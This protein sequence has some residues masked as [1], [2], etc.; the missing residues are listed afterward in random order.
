[1]I[2]LEGQRTLGPWGAVG[3]GPGQWLILS[4]AGE[5]PMR[6][7]LRFY[8]VQGLPMVGCGENKLIE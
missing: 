6:L 2:Q 8:G 1:M 4:G 5:A 3:L 7:S